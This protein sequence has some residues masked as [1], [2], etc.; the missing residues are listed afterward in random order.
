[1]GKLIVSNVMS[2]DGFFEDSNKKLDW[3]VLDEDFFAY[4]RDML[5]SAAALVFGR[6]T[7]EHMASYW[8]SAPKDEIAEKMNNLPKIVFS[9]TLEKAEWN[10]SRLA[11][12]DAVD[13]ITRLKQ[14]SGNA[15]ILGSATLASSLLQL[16][17]I[18]EYRVILNPILIGSG[19]PL[20]KGIRDRVRLKLQETKL[21]SSG[22][23]VL[24]YQK[25]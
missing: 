16:G 8:P 17:L 14:Q 25:A 3:F 24:Y 5:R 21:L 22:G 4:S 9:R 7:Y 20:F 13:E 15:I 2:L 11:E 1:M 19:H 12:G 10:D 18:D 23:V 6:V